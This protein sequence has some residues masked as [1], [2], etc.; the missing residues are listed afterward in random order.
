[1]NGGAGL[2]VGDV[3]GKIDGEDR[4]KQ[5][6]AQKAITSAADEAIGFNASAKKATGTAGKEPKRQAS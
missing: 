2:S 5:D 1:M 3:D 6:D 4:G